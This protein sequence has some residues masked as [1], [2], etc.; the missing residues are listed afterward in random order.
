M[1]SRNDSP[2]GGSATIGVTGASN[3]ADYLVKDT[4]KDG[5]EITIRAMPISTEH[6]NATRRIMTEFHDPDLMLWWEKNL[7][8]L[9]HEVAR[10]ALLCRVKILEPGV[11]ERV[12][13]KDASVCGTENPVAFT[14]LHDM[15]MMHFAIHKK[16]VEALGTAQTAQIEAL[17]IERLKKPF[18]ELLEG[19]GSS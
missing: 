14:K 16:S 4:L 8:E 5:S 12:L 3:V 15:L 9:D 10:L 17:V 7:D 19:R 1:R 18:A 2:Y 13:H 6:F 11:V